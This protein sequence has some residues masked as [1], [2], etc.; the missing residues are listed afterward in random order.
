[1][2]AQSLP[3]SGISLLVVCSVYALMGIIV[4]LIN[5]IMTLVG[6]RFMDRNILLFSIF[7]SLFGIFFQIDL[8][9]KGLISAHIIGF[10]IS[11]IGIEIMDVPMGQLIAKVAP[12]HTMRGY[13]NPSFTVTIASTLGRSIGCLSIT[14]ADISHV[15]G[16]THLQSIANYTFIPLFMMYLT[17]FLI[18][19]CS[20]QQFKSSSQFQH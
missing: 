9:N 5:K 20:Y 6:Y 14:L 11:F 1:M 4:L 8:I 17:L 13:F 12:V 15:I 10:S 18:S 7:A 3:L 16:G 2:T 19:I